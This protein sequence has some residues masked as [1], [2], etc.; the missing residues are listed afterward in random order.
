MRS[1]N[2]QNKIREMKIKQSKD[3]MK[4]SFYGSGFS[5]GPI[6]EVEDKQGKQI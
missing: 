4:V 2:L 6:F 3:E 5:L 1:Q